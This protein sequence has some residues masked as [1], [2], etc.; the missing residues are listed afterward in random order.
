[1]ATAEVDGRKVRA[2]ERREE[3][4]ERL[5]AAA[6]DV[7]ADQGFHAGT[8]KAITQR[9]GVAEGLLFHYFPT[10]ADLL[11]AVLARDPLGPEMRRLLEEEAGQPIA[12]ALPR[13][14]RRWLAVIRAHQPVTR[15]LLQEAHVDPGVQ[16]AMVSLARS[17]TELLA[18][19]FAERR[20]AGELRAIDPQVAA[21]M[22]LQSL[23]GLIM[24]CGDA[25]PG[26]EE[27]VLDRQIDLLLYGMLASSPAR[28]AS[29][30]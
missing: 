17:T 14:A 8:T 11:A 5:L 21:R 26:D 2:A 23:F 29:R 19:Y 1:M 15:V 13:M 16:R 10:K 24:L 27:A 4:R 20:A 3:S 30:G 25:P 9:A 18:G 7:F 12:E 22:L 6:L 28:P